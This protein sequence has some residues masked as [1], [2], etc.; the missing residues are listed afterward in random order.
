MD[1]E[2]EWVH[3]GVKLAD[4]ARMIE[5]ADWEYSGPWGV[6]AAFN[7]LKV[8]KDDWQ[9]EEDRIQARQ[10]ALYDQRPE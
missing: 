5:Y 6:T 4:V 10:E 7:M 1:I 9:E 8:K 2:N 3:I